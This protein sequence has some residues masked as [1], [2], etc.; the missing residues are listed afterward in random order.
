MAQRDLLEMV[1]E[2]EAGVRPPPFPAAVERLHQRN[3]WL[4][5]AGTATPLHRAPYMNLLCQVIALICHCQT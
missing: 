2:L 4:G 5:P 3:T 1:P